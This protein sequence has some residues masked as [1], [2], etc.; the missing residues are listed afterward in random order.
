[1]TE[2]QPIP[3]SIEAVFAK[4]LLVYGASRVDATYRGQNIGQVKAHWAHELRGIAPSGI[5]YGLQNLPADNVPNVLQFRA[6]CMR[7]PETPQKRLPPPTPHPDH[8][9]AVQARLEGLTRAMTGARDP[10]AWAWR[11]RERELGGERLPPAHRVMYRA[12]LSRE[13]E[14]IEAQ[15]YA[16]AQGGAE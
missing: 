7:A 8:V 3:A 6:A 11:L 15:A 12:A 5:A 4:L 13:L 16:Q 14:A 10:K 2:G 9:R 1:M